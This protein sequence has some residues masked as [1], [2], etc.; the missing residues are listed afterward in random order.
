MESLN[1]SLSPPRSPHQRLAGIVFG[2]RLVDKLRASLPGGERAGYLPVTGFSLVWAHYTKIDLKQLREVVASATTES[3]VESWVEDRTRTLD[4]DA[5]NAKMTN[6][7]I[8]RMPAEYVG[9]F[10]KIYPPELREEH[11]NLFDLLEADDAR[12]YPQHV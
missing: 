12:L 8:S 6:W 1:L 4:K 10:S 5:I 7:N 11:T 3:E 2:A 9:L